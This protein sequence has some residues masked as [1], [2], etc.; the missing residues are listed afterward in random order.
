MRSTHCLGSRWSRR[1]PAGGA[2]NFPALLCPVGHWG[3]GKACEDYQHFALRLLDDPTEIWR[4]A[5]EKQISHAARSALLAL[6]SLNGRVS[7]SRLTEAF[8]ALHTARA[9]RYGF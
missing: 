4:H 5:Y 8:D 9:A 2:A 6:H 7:H 3:A 1:V